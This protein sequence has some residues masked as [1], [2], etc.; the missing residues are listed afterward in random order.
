MN[1][2]RTIGIFA[3]T[4]MAAYGA[5]AQDINADKSGAC[6][7]PNYTCSSTS[8]STVGKLTALFSKSSPYNSTAYSPL[9]PTRDCITRITDN[10]TKNPLS[11]KNDATTFSEGNLTTSGSDNEVMTS[12]TTQ[13]VGIRA[14]TGGTNVFHMDA[15]G[16]C[17]Q[18]V[19]SGTG[20]PSIAV[21]GPFSFSHVNDTVFYY[22]E[23]H[24]LLQKATITSDKSYTLTNDSKFPFDFNK[25][26]GPIEGGE[27]ESG[28]SLSVSSTDT[29]FSVNISW[30]GG[31]G[32]SHL[33]LVYKPGS[34]CAVLDLATG[35]RYS[36]CAS[37]CSTKAAAGTETVCTDPDYKKKEGIHDSAMSFDGKVVVIA[38]GC[39]N[40]L[41]YGNTAL[42]QI[43]TD[44]VLGTGSGSTTWGGGVNASGHES[45]GVTGWLRTNYPS[46]NSRLVSPL[47]ETTLS[48][49]NSLNTL[50]SGAGGDGGFHG[51]WPHPA[52][53]DSNAW[54]L[55]SA[56]S[57]GYRNPGYLQNEV[58]AITQTPDAP[59]PRFTPTYNSAKSKNFSCRYGIGFPS[60]DGHWWF[61]LSD[62][63]QTL[64][65][66]SKGHLLCS[67][68]AV[69]LE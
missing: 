14:N 8:T 61:F 41:G 55:E 69:K 46:P 45:V 34:G 24:H 6:G 59:M 44:I 29:Q 42:W 3:F 13:Y 60:Q 28:S 32:T 15:S 39:W 67:V 36:W 33:V 49:Y 57:D 43:N 21:A 51:G 5:V 40:P 66:D 53:D 22:V 58:F 1:L 31:Q 64:G 54:I 63:L 65:N 27:A 26:P 18:N 68:F 17:I 4:F 2:F 10:N 7:P 37:N 25:C 35:K 9:N 62:H 47:S 48:D 23:D 11:P 12:L 52:G 38:G 56:N 30:T 19:T 50:P 20:N 16:P